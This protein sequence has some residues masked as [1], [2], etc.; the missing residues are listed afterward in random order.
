[1]KLKEA[2]ILGP[3]KALKA[4]FPNEAPLIA[5]PKA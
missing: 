4:K 5:E 1:M 2:N 3:C